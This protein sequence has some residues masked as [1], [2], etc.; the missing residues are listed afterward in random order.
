MRVLGEQERADGFLRKALAALTSTSGS[1]S[2]FDNPGDQLEALGAYMAEVLEPQA[3]LSMIVDIA[4]PEAG[5]RGNP[6]RAIAGLF[7][8]VLGRR[9]ARAAQQLES[10]IEASRAGCGV[11]LRARMAAAWHARGHHRNAVDRFTLALAQGSQQT[12]DTALDIVTEGAPVLG[13]LDRGSSLDQVYSA[14]RELQRWA[15]GQDEA[16]T[17]PVRISR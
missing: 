16:R 3:A 7:R 12:A 9:G 8:A 4:L 5:R 10:E 2:S 13:A 15:V 17:G 14:L 6:N 1:T 11:W